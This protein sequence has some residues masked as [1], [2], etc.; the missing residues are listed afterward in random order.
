MAIDPKEKSF[1]PINIKMPAHSNNEKSLKLRKK[2]S[3]RLIMDHS[4]NLLWFNMIRKK[5]LVERI[6]INRHNRRNL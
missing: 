5:C 4:L 2:I 1:P 3:I 6:I